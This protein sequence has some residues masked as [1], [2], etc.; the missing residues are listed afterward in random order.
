[1]FSP[2]K[3]KFDAVYASLKTDFKIDYYG[4]LEKHLG[5]KS[6]KMI[7]NLILG[8]D[9]SSENPTPMVNTTLSENKGAQ[10]RIN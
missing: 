10:T 9:K 6:P 1:M 3:D 4:K 5:I 8:M 7:I 2:S